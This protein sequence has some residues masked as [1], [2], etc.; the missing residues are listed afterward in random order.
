MEA[1]ARPA[2]SF[3]PGLPHPGKKLV[4]VAGVHGDVGSPRVRI[5]EEDPFP[6]LAA[7]LCAVNAAFLLGTVAVAHGRHEDDVGILRMD[8]DSAYPACPVEAHVGPCFSCIGR[9]VRTVADGQV[10]VV[11]S[12]PGLAGAGPDDV[13]VGRRYRHLPDEGDFLVIEDR[14]PGDAAVDGLV[15]AAC[16][17]SGVVD[18]GIAGNPGYRRDAVARGSDMPVLE[19][20]E[21]LRIYRL[22]AGLI[23]C[24]HDKSQGQYRDWIE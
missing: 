24:K 4:R 10:L 17:V 20:I 15:D 8:H 16:R 2:A 13:G 6:G 23:A 21:D 18:P 11:V 19:L 12:E 1:A 9:L 7:I 5:D 3:A 22:G 14:E